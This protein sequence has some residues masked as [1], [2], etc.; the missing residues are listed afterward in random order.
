MDVSRLCPLSCACVWKHGYCTLQTVI[1][2]QPL[3]RLWNLL[4]KTRSLT[5]SCASPAPNARVRVYLPAS[6]PRAARA[7]QHVPS[8]AGCWRV[9]AAASLCIAAAAA[10]RARHRRHPQR[11][12]LRRRHRSPRTPSPQPRALGTMGH[13][14]RAPR[15]RPAS[16]SPPAGSIGRA[17]ARSSETQEVR[18]RRRRC[19]PQ[20]GR[21]WVRAGERRHEV[22]RQVE[23][24]GGAAGGGG[25]QAG[26]GAC[27]SGER[28][29]LAPGALC[30]P[31]RRARRRVP[32]RA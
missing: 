16:P 2:P 1:P 15:L 21:R 6:P 3:L 26:R 17:Q 32:T 19:G 8:R 25:G 20:A 23:L 28:R 12:A 31:L 27:T 4:Y 29:A 24:E 7:T 18:P 30:R 22:V 5:R 9:A 14:S 13:T 10:R 11:S